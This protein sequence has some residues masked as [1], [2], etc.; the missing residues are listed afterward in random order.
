MTNYKLT[1]CY[2][3]SRYR[4]WQRQ[5]NCENSI[6]ALVERALSRL[7][8]QEIEVAGSGRTD[9]GVHARRQVCSFRAETPLTPE[10]CPRMWA[11]S[12]S[13]RRRRAFTPA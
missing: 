10:C 1:L 8:E 3:G 7:L 5:G 2:D 4:G 12:R 9:A 13:R 6:Q 11:R